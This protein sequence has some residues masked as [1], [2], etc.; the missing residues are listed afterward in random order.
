MSYPG[1]N[2][3]VRATLLPLF[4]AIAVLKLTLRPHR[5]K[6]GA[7]SMACLCPGADGN[8]TLD[9]GDI[10]TWQ[11]PALSDGFIIPRAQGE[12]LKLLAPPEPDFG[13]F[14][15]AIDLQ[16]INSAAG[17]GNFQ[18]TRSANSLSSQM[19]QDLSGSAPAFFSARRIVAWPWGMI[20]IPARSK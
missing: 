12:N 17:Q 15:T 16:L 20:S 10:Q 5:G 8:A 3:E 11:N 7:K 4:R 19:D 1:Q 14:E 9:Q 18:V 6:A 13:H 2:Q